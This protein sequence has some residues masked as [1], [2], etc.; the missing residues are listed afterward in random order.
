MGSMS[1]MAATPSGAESLLKM[2][3]QDAGGL[4]GGFGNLTSL[5]SNLFSGGATG[6]GMLSSLLGPGLNAIGGALDQGTWL[7]RDAAARPGRP[8]VDGP[9]QQEGPERQARR[10]WPGPSC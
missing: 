3:P 1:K 10:R 2:L 8:G 5:I 6:D 9:D 4:M 7:Q